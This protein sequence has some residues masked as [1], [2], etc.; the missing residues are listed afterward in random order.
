MHTGKGAVPRKRGAYDDA[1]NIKHNA[2]ILF[3]VNH[4]GGIGAEAAAWVFTLKER[5]KAHDTTA[6]VQGGPTKWVEHWMQRLSMA[7]V[8]ADARRCLR[9]MPG[10]RAKAARDAAARQGAMAGGAARR[11]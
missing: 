11:A 4:F 9:R 5:A 8:A 2:V 6:Y 1:I 10:L 3:M 7:A